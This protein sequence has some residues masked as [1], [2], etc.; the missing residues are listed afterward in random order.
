MK[1][2]TPTSAYMERRP[3]LAAEGR[4]L[5]EPVNVFHRSGTARSR[6]FHIFHR[7]SQFIAHPFADSLTV[8]KTRGYNRRALLPPGSWIGGIP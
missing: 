3:S 5:N 8:E 4:A 7:F 1:E 6:V 2:P